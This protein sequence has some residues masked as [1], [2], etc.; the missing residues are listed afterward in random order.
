M[1]AVVLAGGWEGGV[2]PLNRQCPKAL[3]PLA[4]VPLLAYTFGYLAREGIQDVVVCINEAARSIRDRFPDGRPWGITLRYAPEPV[5]LGTA[6][7]LRGLQTLLGRDPFVVIAGLPFLDFPLAQWIATHRER[8]AIITVALT[9]EQPAGFAEEVV[10]DGDGL[11]EQIVSPYDQGARTRSRT[12]GVYILEPRTFEFIG[13]ESYLDLKEQ[14]IPRIRRAGFSVV[15]TR[16]PG[17][18]VRL[19]TLASYFEFCHSFPNNG[20]MRWDSASQEQLI[21]LGVGVS[22]SR[23]ARLR[24]P[25]LVGEGSTIAERTLVEGP[26]SIGEAC[27]LRAGSVVLASV[28]MEGVQVSEDARLQRCVV[29]PGCHVPRGKV[30][31]DHLLLGLNHLAQG[32]FMAVHL[33][34][35]LD[36]HPVSGTVQRGAHSASGRTLRQWSRRAMKRTLDLS[37]ATVGLV[38]AVPVLMVAALAIK[39]DSPGPVIFRQRRVGKAGRE[40]TMIKLRTM[41]ADAE[42]LQESLADR[43]ELDGPM[44]KIGNDPR[45]T[46]VGRLLRWTRIDELPQL[47][48]VLRGEMSLVGPR[49]LAMKE[50]KY[51]PAWRDLRLT[52]KPGITGVWQVESSR[53]NTF[54]DWIA[55][56]IRYVE[57]QSLRLDLQILGQTVREV[58]RT[59][60]TRER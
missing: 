11:V 6:G 10:L 25:L 31:A 3:L 55:A 54:Q 26:T 60:W 15:A 23:S 30:F 24:G 28:L 56:D 43:N 5:P 51:H 22:V 37:L 16:V 50:M 7:C 53:K 21:R 12:L 13:Q 57:K 29:A 2:A 41:V 17:I 9:D 59:L 58:W 39:L 33:Q 20:L 40:F 52:V 32:S 49:P 36:L 47:V 1:K 4:N 19:D 27:T 34:G 42:T 45:M 46:R 44:F 14:L 48:N 18:G 8:R 38:V 35:G